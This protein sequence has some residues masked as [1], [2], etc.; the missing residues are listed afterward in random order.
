[1]KDFYFLLFLRKQLFLQIIL[2]FLSFWF[3]CKYSALKTRCIASIYTFHYVLLLFTEEAT[4]VDGSYSAYNP[5][6]EGSKEQIR[7]SSQMLANLRQSQD[8]L[9]NIGLSNVDSSENRK[10]C[11]YQV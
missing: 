11:L 4:V 1:M 8:S 6:F 9:Q 5:P 3:Q 7:T 2:A 10:K